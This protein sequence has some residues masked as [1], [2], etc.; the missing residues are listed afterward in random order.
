M[1]TE[2]LRTG[3]SGW[4]WCTPARAGWVCEAINQPHGLG[5]CLFVWNRILLLSFAT[6]H[7]FL[8][9][10]VGGGPHGAAIG[11]FATVVG[12]GHRGCRLRIPYSVGWAGGG[13][14]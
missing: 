10:Q 12:W 11:T 1:G 4:G 9:L 3:E 8:C 5:C 13:W 6:L 2:T 14:A 7:G